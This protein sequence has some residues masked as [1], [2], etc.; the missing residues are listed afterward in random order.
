MSQSPIF[1]PSHRVAGVG[2]GAWLW[3][4]CVPRRIV[5]RALPVTNRPC[6]TPYEE[7][8]VY[9]PVAYFSVESP[10][11]SHSTQIASRSSCAA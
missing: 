6:H 8:P 4:W 2:I 10:R 5:W 3:F 11:C 9:E 7:A 1:L